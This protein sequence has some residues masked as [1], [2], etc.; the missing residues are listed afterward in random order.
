VRGAGGDG[1]LVAVRD[2]ASAGSG[3]DAD[4][5]DGERGD[6]NADGGYVWAWCVADFA[7]YGWV[8]GDDG[9]VQPCLIDIC[10]DDV[11]GYDRGAGGDVAGDGDNGANGDRGGVYGLGGWGFQ[12]YE[13]LLGNCSGEERDLPGEGELYADLINGS[14]RKRIAAGSGT[15]VQDVNQLLRQYAQMSKM[16]KQMGKGGMM[17]NMMRGGMA[18]MMGGSPKQKF[19][20]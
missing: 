6:S 17:K 15:D 13:S 9:S 12:Q 11:G 20:R 5:D 16:F 10:G 7:G 2:G 4:G 3:N 19:G 1:L 18:G 8:G 14:R